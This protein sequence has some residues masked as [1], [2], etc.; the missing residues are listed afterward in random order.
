MNVQKVIVYLWLLL[1]IIGIAILIPA[2]PEL[3]AYYGITDFQV[4]LWLTIYSLG[5]FFAAPVLGQLSDKYGRKNI[6]AFCI[7]WT[8]ISYALLLFGR[9]Y[10]LFL[11]SRV[12]NG[13]TGGNVSILQAILT[14]I[15]PDPETK[16]KNFWLM[17]AFFGVWFIIWPLIGS[18]LLKFS[19]IEGVF[20]FGV[21]F[22]AVEL[23]LILLHFRNTNHLEELKKISFN[24]F[25]VMGK[26]LRKETMR[27]FLLSL[28]FLGVGGFSINASLSLFMNTTFATSGVMYGYFLAFAGVIN[29]VNMGFF[30]P[31]FWTK[32]FSIHQLI[33]R[34]HIALICWYAI[35]WT[36]TNYTL[37]II[38]FYVVTMLSGI[39]MPIYNIQIMS[40]AKPDEI[41]ELS[42]MLGG[43]Q[44]LFM[45]VGPLL[46]WVLLTY[47]GNIFWWAV[48][49]F[50]ASGVCMMKWM[51]KKAV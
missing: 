47:G 27:N 34:V 11:L 25:H 30:V 31:R 2:F 29:A 8:L 6:L 7:A 33:I 12:I 48:V 20:W 51:V 36:V 19:N 49:C 28:F 26:Y 23:G 24:A 50:L 13:I 44:S 17:G 35:L 21:I 9:S 22:S 46:W 14:D 40:Q 10:R 3:K 32:R 4:T 5:A 39:Y 41:G 15:S 18:M 1:D 16:S 42:G 45:F 38:L 37:F 43:A